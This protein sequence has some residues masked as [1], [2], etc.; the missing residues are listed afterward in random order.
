MAVY[1]YYPGSKR[2][3]DVANPC[4]VIDKFTCD[5]IVKNGIL[6]DDN[7]SILKEVRYVYGGVDSNDPRCDL[8]LVK[9]NN[10]CYDDLFQY[11][12]PLAISN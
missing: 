4:S 9:Y 8:F 2:R 7:V 6:V 1:V 5:A 11:A 12:E 10:G 3:V